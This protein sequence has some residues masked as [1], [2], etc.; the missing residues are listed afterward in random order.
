MRNNWSRLFGVLSLFA[1][2]AAVAVAVG[3]SIASALTVETW[4]ANFAFA[5]LVMSVLTAFAVVLSYGASIKIIRVARAAWFV[6]ALVCLAFV[7]YVLSLSYA[8]THKAA[9]TVL[10]LTMFIL[11]FPAG[12]IAIGFA[13]VYSSLV[14]PDRG[15]RPMDVMVIWAVFLAAGYI[16]WFKLLPYLIEKWRGRRSHASPS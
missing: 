8:D 7:Q 1:L 9:D 15:M 10:L 16:Q 4:R 12:T 6:V 3:F 13:F 2:G 11:A 14:L 5:L